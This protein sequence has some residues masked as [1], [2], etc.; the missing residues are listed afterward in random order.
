MNAGLDVTPTE[1]MV[2]MADEEDAAIGQEE[3]GLMTYIA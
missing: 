3:D 1:P 2:D